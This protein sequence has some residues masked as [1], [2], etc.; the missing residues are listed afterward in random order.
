MGK[1]V[2]VGARVDTEVHRQVRELA[3]GRG[4]SEAKVVRPAI[5]PV[6]YGRNTRILDWLKSFR[7]TESAFQG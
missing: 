4:V 1:S 3:L 2:M 7:S 5:A 6:T